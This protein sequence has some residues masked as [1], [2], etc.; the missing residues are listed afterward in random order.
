[1]KDRLKKRKNTIQRKN[2]RARTMDLTPE[3]NKRERDG[4]GPVHG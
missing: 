2:R 3:M 1:M 4:W